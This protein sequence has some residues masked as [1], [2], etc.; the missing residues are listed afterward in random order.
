MTSAGLILAMMVFWIILG[1]QFIA[2]EKRIAQLDKE[3]TSLKPTLQKVDKLKKDKEV[4]SRRLKFMDENIKRDILWSESLNR[5]S[6]L[7]PP[8]IWLK[9]MVLRTQKKEALN[10]Y[11][12]LDING[13]AISLSGQEMI[14]LIGGFMTLIKRD[15]VFSKQFSEIKLI[16]SQ[17]IK[18]DSKI[19]VMDFKLSCQ[20]R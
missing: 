12:K 16:S 9:E 8:G 3:L 20:F 5:L 15:E 6:N 14:D 10:I 4:F 1:M 19:E 2:R 7:V 13:S 11:D 18:K 17:R